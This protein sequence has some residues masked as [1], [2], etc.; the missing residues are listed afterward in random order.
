MS[1]PTGDYRRRRSGSRAG[2]GSGFFGWRGTIPFSFGRRATVYL[3][4]LI[5]LCLTAGSVRAQHVWVRAYENE[6]D[7]WESYREGEITGEQY[8][9][10]V[11]LFRAG[12][13]SMFQ[14]P[15]DIDELPGSMIADSLIGISGRPAGEPR[16]L[17]RRFDLRWGYTLPLREETDDEGYFIGR[18]SSARVKLYLNCRTGQGRLDGFRKRGL[19]IGFLNGRTRVAF[20][21]IEPRFG[22][23]LV[24]G[25]RDRVLGRT[26]ATRLSGSIWQP[27]YA[28]YNGFQ[29][30]QTLG[31]TARLTVLGSR[32][33]SSPYRED[34]A[35][36]HVSVGGSAHV[37]TAGITGA[38]YLMAR[39]DEGKKFRRG[40]VSFYL[41]RERQHAGLQAEF[42]L[43]DG[44][45]AAATVKAVKPMKAGRFS[46]ALWTRDP[47]FILPSSGGP[48]HPGRRRVVIFDDDLD[49][50]SRT[51]GEQG[52]LAQLRTRIN[53]KMSYETV[54]E[55]YNDRLENTKNIE[56][57]VAVRATLPQKTSL[58]I[59]LRGR[60]TRG[61]EFSEHR[62]YAG[63]HGRTRAII[64]SRSAWRF[65]YGTIRRANAGIVNSLRMELSTTLQVNELVTFTPR[66]R[67]VDPAVSVAGDG[68]YYFYLT[69]GIAPA[70]HWRLELVMVVKGYEDATRETYADIR[71]RMSCRL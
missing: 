39:R 14:P 37:F 19:A 65:E 18:W 68:Y 50:Y 45:T 32:I 52:M 46:I 34:I 69:E 71:V 23:G 2:P 30:E 10:L 49:F 29:I 24:V 31:A 59:Y 21:N 22:L 16:D 7:L 8:L 66:L 63:L 26:A 44:G 4:V 17:P 11:E 53:N 42:A 35:A 55:V 67:Y 54:F 3:G 51:A 20:G 28:F 47:D 70:R 40:G 9:E 62:L 61:L 38:A 5:F 56:G 64:G 15:S 27:K 33:E 25:R 36:V 43:G 60:D 6:E 1:V 57:R 58:A 13:D 41:A 12:V 48:G